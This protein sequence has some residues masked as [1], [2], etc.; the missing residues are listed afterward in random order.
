MEAHEIFERFLAAGDRIANSWNIEEGFSGLAHAAQ[1]VLGAKSVALIVA[2]EDSPYLR[3]ISSV[4][5]SGTF[6]N[7][8]KPSL[9]DNPV[10]QRVVLGREPVSLEDLSVAGPECDALRLECQYGS[11]L[12]MP[13][14]AMHRSVGLIVAASDEPRYFTAARVVLLRLVAHMAA[15][16]HTRCALYDE[17]RR[18]AAIDPDTGLW[19]FEFF[20]HRLDEEIARCCR[21]RL[22]LA[23]LLLDVDGF[24]RFKES[25]GEQAADEL[26]ATFIAVTRSTMRGIDLL[27]RL[28]LDDLLVVLPQTDLQGAKVAAERSLAAIRGAKFPRPDVCVTCSVGVATLHPGETEAGAILA[29]VQKCLYTARLKGQG[30]IAT[31]AE[32]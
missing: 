17:R 27:G 14:V 19:T 22:P 21:H 23:L 26:F 1:A 18:L 13:I 25:F 2:G 12:A 31:E 7:H 11:V 4:G 9:Q 20:C 8:Y 3:I 29:R 10:L 30:A 24:L 6:I 32:I 28:G 15:G 16:C 5:L